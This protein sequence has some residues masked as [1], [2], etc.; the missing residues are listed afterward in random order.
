[1]DKYFNNN[2]ELHSTA[3]SGNINKGQ[4]VFE[5]VRISS[6]FSGRRQKTE[7]QGRMVLTIIVQR[8]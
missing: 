7:K 6:L 8:N 3:P 2:D 1:M 4:R 5:I